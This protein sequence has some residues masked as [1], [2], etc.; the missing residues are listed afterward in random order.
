MRPRCV[1]ARFRPSQQDNAMQP[2]Q[3]ANAMSLEIFH[4]IFET[5]PRHVATLVT[6]SPLDDAL[7]AA[8]EGTQNV[9]GSW[10]LD[11]GFNGVKV[12]PSPEVIA[13]QGC[14]STS[15]GDYVR[16]VNAQGSESFYRCRGQNW[17]PILERAEL[18]RVGVNL[19]TEAIFG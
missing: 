2:Q 17:A 8:F 12:T 5:A 19:M 13:A 1:A 4:T 7:E 15:P 6:T 10:V 11:G 9:E 3:A 14:R 18:A 16:V